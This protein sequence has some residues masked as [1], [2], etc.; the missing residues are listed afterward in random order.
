[1]QS[2]GAGRRRTSRV[3]PADDRDHYRG[4]DAAGGSPGWEFIRREHTRVLPT[5][6]SASRLGHKNFPLRDR[7]RRPGTGVDL[8]QTADQG[9][10]L[11]ECPPGTAK[12]ASAKGLASPYIW[13]RV[14]EVPNP[15]CR[16]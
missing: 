16:R 5:R 15:D 1:M 8:N 14:R 9:G 11:D 3:R 12:H 4:T 2:G 7:V 6:R 10:R 13:A